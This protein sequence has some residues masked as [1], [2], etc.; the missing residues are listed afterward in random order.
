MLNCTA[1]VLVDFKPK[2]FFSFVVY[3]SADS[4]MAIWGVSFCPLATLLDLIIDYQDK[5]IALSNKGKNGN[6]G[7]DCSCS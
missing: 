6:R 5:M 1:F 3:T 2:E 4:D 7:H